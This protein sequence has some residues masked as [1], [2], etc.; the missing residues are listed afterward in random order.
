MNPSKEN[1]RSLRELLAKYS[2]LPPHGQ[3]YFVSRMEEY[4]RAPSAHRRRLAQAWAAI[5]E[6][7]A[8]GKGE[9]A[10]AT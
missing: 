7:D 5:H 9:T 8:P 4:L 6:I 2:M 3:Q 1:E 10:E